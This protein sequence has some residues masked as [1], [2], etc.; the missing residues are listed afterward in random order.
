VVHINGIDVHYEVRGEG[1]WLVLIAGLGVD[2][3][4]FAHYAE[5]LA[6]HYRVLIFDNRGAGRSGKPD[7]AYSIAMM[8]HDTVS[9]MDALNI[10]HAHILG[11]SMGGRIA[12][13]LAL[14]Y[15]HRVDRLVLVS[16]SPSQQKRL[17]AITK[18]IKHVRSL[19]RTQQPYYAFI[20][21][22]AASADYDCTARLDQI[23]TP[24]LIA[25]GR[26]DQLATQ[27]QAEEMA[28]HIA[29]CT[30]V[31]F[32]GGHLFFLLYADQLIRQVLKFLD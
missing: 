32:K 10:D 6:D 23:T 25:Y 15:P 8:A 27:R 16:T 14:T 3:S 5:V 17:P 29:N 19:S 4:I 28:K 30:V 22:L 7:V 21:Q 24:T 26:N 20:R 13:E 1:V 9:L 2:S 31:G 12:M 11:V 18:I